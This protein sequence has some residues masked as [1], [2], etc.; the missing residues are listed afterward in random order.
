M[1]LFSEPSIKSSHEPTE[2]SSTS[3][4]GPNWMTL[5][6]SYNTTPKPI[7][8]PLQEENSIQSTEGI[9]KNSTESVNE[10]IQTETLLESE[11]HKS[12]KI[13]IQEIIPEVKE[14]PMTERPKPEAN[15]NS[16]EELASSENINQS[17]ELQNGTNVKEENDV[18]TFD[19]DVDSSEISEIYHHPPPPVLR[20]GDKLLFLKKGELVPEKDTSTPAAV[21]TIIGAEGLQRGFEDSGEVHETQLKESDK[22]KEA[23]DSPDSIPS[24]ST[25]IISL[26]K[27]NKKEDT[28]KTTE[29]VTEGLHVIP[30]EKTVEDDDNNLSRNSTVITT[31]EESPVTESI[32]E[33]IVPDLPAA[34]EKAES[35][36]TITTL[37][38]TTT[39]EIEIRTESLEN[40]TLVNNCENLTTEVN[41][42]EI[43]STAAPILAA[44]EN[45]EEPV[46]LEEN[47]AYPPIPD[48]MVPEESEEPIEHVE[49]ESVLIKH[50]TKEEIQT[51]TSTPIAKI[52]PEV[53]EIRNN[54][55]LPLNISHT[56][57]L[58]EETKNDTTTSLV[59]LDAALPDA[60]IREAVAS[61]FDGVTDSYHD[62]NEELTTMITDKSTQEVTTIS[63]QNP[64]STT[65][66]GSIVDQSVLT[67]NQVLLLA[68]EPRT[69]NEGIVR[70]SEEDK[71]KESIEIVSQDS[72]EATT[73]PTKHES[74]MSNE[75]A[76]VDLATNDSPE[77]SEGD[78]MEINPEESDNSKESE[79]KSLELKDD[80]K[81]N[82]KVVQKEADVEM[83]DPIS[84]SQTSATSTSNKNKE[85]AGG[86]AKAVEKRENSMDQ[87]I[88][89][90]L[91]EELKAANTE[92]I[93]TKQEEEREAE[94]IFKQLLEEVTPTPKSQ[95]TKTAPPAEGRNKDTEA[96]QRVSDAISRFQLRDNK[97]SL[98]TSILGILRD[99][100]TSQYRSYDG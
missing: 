4:E 55:T 34:T 62:N 14:I 5:Q 86:P 22:Q 82:G 63:Q 52:L 17:G 96:L 20:I 29:V 32:T 61:D 42:M 84:L 87:Q 80:P 6:T 58:K 43:S 26:V 59:N 47:P 35:I 45:K 54:Q 81:T 68:D 83:F 48:I 89:Q 49:Q 70:L 41:I 21:I 66:F 38:E 57:W 76:S 94:E 51:T 95:T 46:V 69:S 28:E 12:P 27:L 100:F 23:T 10:G 85:E 13:T 16:Q 3:K 9:E 99:F 79:N 78:I 77:Q 40:D 74:L 71:S 53:L 56:E 75:N 97:A 37:L 31:T 30:L 39:E 98:D 73:K 7:F 67:Q 60:I 44:E 90:Q 2:V 92:R 11:Q 88:F 24:E 1:K 25:H 19:V 50:I 15:S 18:V 93:Q 65:T 91:D 8:Y 33:T 72:G 64:E 36:P